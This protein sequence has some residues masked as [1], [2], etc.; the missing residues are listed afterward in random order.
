MSLISAC[1]CA[2][3]RPASTRTAHVSPSLPLSRCLCAHHCQHPR[4][5]PVVPVCTCLY[6]TY[7]V[8]DR[9]T[10]VS[11]AEV[12]ALTS[13][14]LSPADSIFH[15]ML[16]T[17]TCLCQLCIVGLPLQTGWNMCTGPATQFCA[18]CPPS[19]QKGLVR[20]FK[21]CWVF[22]TKLIQEQDLAL[23]G[24]QLS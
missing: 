2:S 17:L 6:L 19:W 14:F 5:I 18:G 12:Y 7:C 1:L 15:W 8:I 21:K 11:R 3:S 10:P 20:T 9:L 16:S 22:L 4:L 13:T 24:P 23:G